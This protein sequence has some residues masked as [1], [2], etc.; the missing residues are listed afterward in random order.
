MR[1][2]WAV[3]RREFAAYFTTPVG[4]VVVGAFAVISGLGFAASFLFYCRVSVSPSEYAYTGVPDFSN[5][6]GKKV[7]TVLYIKADRVPI[8][9]RVFI[10]ASRYLNTDTRP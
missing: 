7:T 2:A 8:A 3:C 1:N 6:P 5:R 10:S 4:Y 9:I